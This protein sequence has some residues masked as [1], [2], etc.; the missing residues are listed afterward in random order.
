VFVS[1]ADAPTQGDQQDH[2]HPFTSGGRS[3]G[4]AHTYTTGNVSGDHAHSL[5]AT[6]TDQGGTL[7]NPHENM[8]PWVALFWIIKAQPSTAASFAALTVIERTR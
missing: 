5:P 8:P 2:S 4:H 3:S 6:N 7:G 1:V